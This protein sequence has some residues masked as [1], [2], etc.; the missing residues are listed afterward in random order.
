VDVRLLPLHLAARAGTTDDTPF[1][2]HGS[3][4][5]F[6]GIEVS[7]R[8]RKAIRGRDRDDAAVGRHASS[9]GNRSG[10]GRQHD[11]AGRSADVD[12]AML[13]GRIGVAPERERPQHGAADGPGPGARAGRQGES[14]C[15]GESCSYVHAHSA[16]SVLKMDNDLRRG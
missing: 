6:D 3:F 14:D 5:N 15:C 2:N 4:C 9:E 1:G 16:S 13:T 7:E 10:G 11:L 8:D 12:T